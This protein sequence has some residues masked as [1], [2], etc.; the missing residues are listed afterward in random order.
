MGP[1]GLCA[2]KWS[3]HVDA[4][5][6]MEIVET[7]RFHRTDARFPRIV[8][9]DINTAKRIESCVYNIRPSL[10]VGDIVM[11]GDGIAAPIQ[12]CIPADLHTVPV[13]IGEHDPRPA[14]GECHATRPAY[15]GSGGAG[16]DRNL[17]V[18]SVHFVL[19]Y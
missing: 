2:K 15:A 17:A 13:E 8:E 14:A 9:Q 1:H 18:Q 11:A 6:E 12:D 10:F 5:Q 7:K 16:N 3:N 4:V 19:S